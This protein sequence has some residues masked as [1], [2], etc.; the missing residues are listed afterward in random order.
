GCLLP[1]REERRGLIGPSS[2]SLSAGSPPAPAGLRATR[3]SLHCEPLVIEAQPIEAT[4][5]LA[6][7]GATGAAMIALRH[8]DT[9]PGMRR[10]NRRIDHQQPARLPSAQESLILPV[11]R[12]HQRTAAARDEHRGLALVAIGDE[13]ALAPLVES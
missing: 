3:S 13:P 6:V 10:C 9:V 11:D 8:H 5:F 1:R 12:R 7:A 2:T 4:E